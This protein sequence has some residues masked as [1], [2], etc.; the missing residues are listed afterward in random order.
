MLLITS[1]FLQ[2]IVYLQDF[3]SFYLFNL[4]ISI[5]IFVDITLY[6]SIIFILIVVIN[7]FLIV[8]EYNKF[9]KQK[10][11]ENKEI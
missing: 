2:I 5:N 4:Q 1:H 9:N 10:R 8:K 3:H 11:I 6:L 7:V